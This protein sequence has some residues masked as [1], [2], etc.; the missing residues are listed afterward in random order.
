MQNVVTIGLFA[1]SNRIK[2]KPEIL[3]SG[4]WFCR[5]LHSGSASSARS[6]S[7]Q[8]ISAAETQ[9]GWTLLFAQQNQ[10]PCVEAQQS[11]V[12]L[13]NCKLNRINIR[14]E[15]HSRISPSKSTPPKGKKQKK[16]LKLESRLKTNRSSLANYRS[17][18]LE[19]KL[20]FQRKEELC[21]RTLQILAPTLSS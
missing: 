9:G 16:L 20:K 11:P 15:N 13:R 17:P 19:T 4:N 7:N 3:C 8:R 10:L 5:H 2:I 14:L 12:P 1:K 21:L 6:V 18:V